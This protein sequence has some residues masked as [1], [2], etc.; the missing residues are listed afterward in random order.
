MKEKIYLNKRTWLNPVGHWNSGAIAYKV[1][2]DEYSVDGTLS[3]WDCSKKITLDL[4]IHDPKSAK[5]VANKVDL[6]LSALTEIKENLGKAYSDL[7]DDPKYE[8]DD[9]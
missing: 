2:R 5:Q 6:M 4:C 8:E 3:F 9:E 7:L 1:M